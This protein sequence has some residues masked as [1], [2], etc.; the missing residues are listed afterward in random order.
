MLQ[1]GDSL[2]IYRLVARIGAGGMGEVWTAEDTRLGRTVAIKILPAAIAS[3]PDAIARM[4]REARTAAQLYH[5]NIA[6]IHAFDQDGDRVYIVMEYVE[7]EPLRNLIPLPEAEVCRIG[8]SVAEA[9]AAAHEKGIV[10]RDVKPDNIIVS[11]SRVKVLD[12]GIAKQVE[13]NSIRADDPTA[14]MTQQGYIVGTVHYMS[15]E[16]AL[17]KPL[18]ARSDLFSLGVVLYEA[19]TGSVPFHGET[20]T[21]TITKIVRDEPRAPRGVSPALAS[22]IRRC[23]AKNRE[24]RFASAADVARALETTVL[25]GSK[26]V[27]VQEPALAMRKRWPWI[28][29][30]FAAVALVV[31][32]AAALRPKKENVIV[33]TPPPTPPSSITVEVHPSTATSPPPVVETHT[34]AAPAPAPVP[35][36]SAESYY[37]AG[38]SQL[39]ERRPLDA[40]E[41][42]TRALEVDP[43]H[44]RAHF[45]L[46]EIALF[47]R[48]GP[49]ARE[50]FTAA[51]ADGDRLADRERKLSELGLALLDRDRGRAL[52][53]YR[54]VM[55]AY[56]LDPDLQHFRQLIEEERPKLAPRGPMRRRRF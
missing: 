39:M 50:Q 33:A 8:K 24:A 56:P 53:I 12:F 44:A 18:D 11:G 52:M 29:A 9:L 6:T 35:I 5:P 37:S 31:I 27:T 21:E 32:A 41:S 2:G 17:G 28:A 45:R 47:A 26:L 40:Y 15:P 48:Q 3:N 1:P 49:E 51:L 30:G 4:Q 46:G 36:R 20:A 22:V 43:H 19:V 7:G 55:D 54:E 10:H 13:Q 38:M 34:L 16:Q 42:F 14:F 25:T 23:M